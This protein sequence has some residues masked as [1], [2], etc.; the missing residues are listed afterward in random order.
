MSDSTAPLAACPLSVNAHVVPWVERLVRG[1]DALGV[2][3]RRDDS[4]A[5]IVDAGIDAP[6]A[7]LARERFLEIIAAGDGERYWPVIAEHIARAG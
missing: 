6:G 1:A 4:G 2:R 7:R 3:L 5:H